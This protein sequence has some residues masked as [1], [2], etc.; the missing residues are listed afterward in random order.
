ML[1]KI[2]EQFRISAPWNLLFTL[3]THVF[4]SLFYQHEQY[5][6]SQFSL[7][8]RHRHAKI[9]FTFTLWNELLN[10]QETHH[11][12]TGLQLDDD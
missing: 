5:H 6:L 1:F 4:S 7:S 11:H 2:P 10:Y 12:P 9:D 3:E 8:L